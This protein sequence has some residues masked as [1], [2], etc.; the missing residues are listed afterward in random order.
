MI[1]KNALWVGGPP[2]KTMDNIQRNLKRVGIKIIA[3][4]KADPHFINIKA[5]I[6]KGVDV[7]LLNHEMC[8]HHAQEH[9]K[10]LCKKEFKRFILAHTNASKTVQELIA[11]GVI[12]PDT[13]VPPEA[14]SVVQPTAPVDQPNLSNP[15][16]SRIWEENGIVYARQVSSGKR[17][18]VRPVVVDG[19]LFMSAVDAAKFLEMDNK[20]LS[21]LL[22]KKT[23]TE[24]KGFLCCYPDLAMAQ[25]LIEIDSA[26]KSNSNSP[27]AVDQ[28]KLVDETVSEMREIRKVVQTDISNLK[29]AAGDSDLEKWRRDTQALRQRYREERD[30]CLA[31]I[32][33]I[34]TILDTI[35]PPG[36]GG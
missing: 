5:N 12:V 23:A 28:V 24:I 15:A 13:L 30:R 7:V 25:Q 17:R 18:R 21:A 2:G 31:R 1:Y 16:W 32:K 34:D 22:L 4:W 6:P 8:S 27:I 33:E 19:T 3:K 9:V 35:L 36:E 20:R 29:A 11:K 10:N 14:I 26:M